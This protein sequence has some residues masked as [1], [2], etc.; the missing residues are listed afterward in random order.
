MLFHLLSSFI[1]VLIVFVAVVVLRVAAGRVALWIQRVIVAA[2]LTLT[3][4]LHVRVL[5][6]A[7]VACIFVVLALH[8]V[9]LLGVG[10]HLTLLKCRLLLLVQALLLLL[11]LDSLEDFSELLVDGGRANDAGRVE[12]VFLGG[13]PLLLVLLVDPLDA[14]QFF[15]F[16]DDNTRLKRHQVEVGAGKFDL[17]VSG[18]LVVCQVQLVEVHFV[19]V[20]NNMVWIFQMDQECAAQEDHSLVDGLIVAVLTQL[21]VLVL[22]HLALLL[23]VLA[24]VL[25]RLGRLGILLEPLEKI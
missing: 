14:E 25:L 9:L 3:L 10:L 21:R 22:V 6:F 18:V 23:A 16:L 5:T 4:E 12:L 1:N 8:L 19:A 20:I 15:H 7:R 11:L 13:L 17:H 2:V 24:I